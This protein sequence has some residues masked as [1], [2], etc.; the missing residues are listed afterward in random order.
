MPLHPDTVYSTVYITYYLLVPVY[1][2]WPD[3]ML[4]RDWPEPVGESCHLRGVDLV[5]EAKLRLR[6]AAGDC[7]V[8]QTPLL[9]CRGFN[10]IL[11]TARAAGNVVA[12]QSGTAGPW[13]VAGMQ[14]MTVRG[15]HVP[16]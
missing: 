4:G 3:T 8:F 10:R 16:R 9:A 13:Q 5:N 14:D 1:V 11:E 12:G 15:Y 2:T 7:F 6:D